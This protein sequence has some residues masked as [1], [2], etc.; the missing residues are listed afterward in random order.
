MI[1]IVQLNKD[2]NQQNIEIVILNGESTNL[3][4]QI[5]LDGRFGNVSVKANRSKR[6]GTYD[7]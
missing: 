1:I 6:S 5:L 7:C 4:L 3:N 2:R